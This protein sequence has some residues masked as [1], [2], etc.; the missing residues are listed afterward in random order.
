MNHLP[1]FLIVITFGLL[2]GCGPDSHPDLNP[3]PVPK[4]EM[5]GE[6]NE[7]NPRGG[8]SVTV[9]WEFV[10]DGPVLSSPAIGADGT[11]YIGSVDK[12]VY[13]LDGATG[14]RKWEFMTGG[15][16]ES[17]P[18]IGADG[19]VYIGSCDKLVYALDGATGA[20]KWSFETGG[21]VLSSPAL[22][23]NGRLYIGS[24][25]GKLY[26]LDSQTGA[27]QW[28]YE[29]GKM[30]LKISEEK[31][32]EYRGVNSS[33]AIG[34]DGTVY[35]GS[36]SGTI[37]ALDGTTG[38]KKWVFRTGLFGRGD[39]VECSPALGIDGT[40][41]AGATTDVYALDGQTGRKKWEFPRAGEIKSSPAI[42]PD[43]TIYVGSTHW[44]VRA[45]DGQTGSK[46]WEFS[47]GQYTYQVSSSPAIGADGT[48]YFG[49]AS[50]SGGN[51]HAVNSETGKHLWTF[52][53]GSPVTSS[54][55]IG[56]DGT[57]YIG[58]ANK[59]VYAIKTDSRGPAQSPWPMRGQNPQRTGQAPDAT[60]TTSTPTKDPQSKVA[61][62][63]S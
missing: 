10:T 63:D 59:K 5:R 38:S 40:V 52:N 9:L 25:D 17:S 26:A 41:Y 34:A 15:R 51:I 1:S 22:G 57:L 54:P 56:S 49:S 31:T 19:T 11:V 39:F 33:P 48:V 12:K 23:A 16:V 6:G 18:A 47:T 8:K 24:G 4:G 62:V 53:T 60:P 28:D 61:P 32:I 20:R 35:G 27:F 55:A 14:K 2:S 36:I 58:S 46:K 42:G 43:G 30:D 37:F 7:G 13:A 29:T 3:G 50:L 21:K 45:L 44:C